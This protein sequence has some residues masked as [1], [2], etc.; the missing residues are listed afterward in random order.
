MHACKDFKRGKH[1]TSGH[2]QTR[3]FMWICHRMP[4][5]NACEEFKRGKQV[6]ER[7]TVILRERG[8]DQKERQKVCERD[9]SETSRPRNSSS[10]KLAA[11]ISHD[12]ERARAHTDSPKSAPPQLVISPVPETSFGHQ[13]KTTG[14][15]V[16]ESGGRSSLQV[17]GLG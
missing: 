6:S 14:V 10:A 7:D 1:S 15:R 16:Q 11:S 13:T 4:V 5:Y 8:W 12:C 17:Q 3:V 9:S 2:S